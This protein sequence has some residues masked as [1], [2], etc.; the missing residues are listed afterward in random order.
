MY[1]VWEDG[2]RGLLPPQ[3]EWYIGRSRH[4]IFGGNKKEDYK[5]TWNQY[6]QRMEIVHQ[7]PW[8]A[9]SKDRREVWREYWLMGFPPKRT[10]AAH[11]APDGWDRV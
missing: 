2:L 7:I 4:Q 3:P 10:I 1:R 6:R 8:K 11:T 5:M 9:L